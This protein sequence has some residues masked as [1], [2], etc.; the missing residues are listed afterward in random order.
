MSESTDDTQA[1]L[2]LRLDLNLRTAIKPSRRTPDFG[3]IAHARRA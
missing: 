1:R 3:Q 2:R